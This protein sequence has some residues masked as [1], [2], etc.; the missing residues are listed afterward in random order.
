MLSCI[1]IDWKPLTWL[2]YTAWIPLYPLGGL[3]E[4]RSKPASLIN[5]EFKAGPV[6][7]FLLLAARLKN[8]KAEQINRHLL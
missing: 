5:N 7:P 1:G 6:K 3:A 4:G 2:R 8:S